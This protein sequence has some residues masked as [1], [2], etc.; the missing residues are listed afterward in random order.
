MWIKEVLLAIMFAFIM[1][2]LI[3]H[4]FSLVKMMVEYD[5]VTKKEKLS[6]MRFMSVVCFFLFIWMTVQYVLGTM[7]YNMNIHVVIGTASFAPK[8]LQKMIEKYIAKL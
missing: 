4:K 5:P 1:Y 6:T 3:K 2:D 8:L 7:A